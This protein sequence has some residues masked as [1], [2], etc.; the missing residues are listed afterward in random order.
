MLACTVQHKAS[1]LEGTCVID[2]VEFAAGRSD[3]N[4]Q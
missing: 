4:R 3:T 2:T 1:V